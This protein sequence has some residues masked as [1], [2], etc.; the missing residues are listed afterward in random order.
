MARPLLLTNSR[1][2]VCGYCAFAIVRGGMVIQAGE[3]LISTGISGSRMGLSQHIFHGASPAMRVLERTIADIAPTDIPILLVGESGTGKEVI[4]LEIHRLSARWK[5]PF[6]KYSCSG[7][8]ADSIAARLHCGENV[9][10]EG[11]MS[12]GSLFLD[13][14]NQLEPAA[15]ARLLS[16]L[17][18][19]CGMPSSG[20]LSV[21]VISS[22]T[23]NLEDEMRNARFR[24]ELY[25]RIN[26]VHLRLPPL[27]SRKED[28]PALLEFFLEKYASLFGRPTPHLSTPTMDLLLRHAWPG[29]IRELENFARKMV[30]LGNEHLATHDLTC[31]DTQKNPE[32]VLS[33]A[34]LPENENAPG[35][36]LKE[37]AR[38]ASRQAERKMILNQLEH[39]RWNRKRTARELQI[40]YKALL[41]KLKQLGLD[42]SDHT[43]GQ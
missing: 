22:T 14:I 9:S 27:R 32:S 16:L 30:A 20:C 3:N 1:A 28:I 5:E 2:T 18:D 42:G 29:N 39:T 8:T 6:V 11:A 40:S 36:S 15:Q 4:A 26:G 13:E 38:E 33:P 37:A 21:R 43:D 31:R 24:E 41:Y 35:R 25:Y 34:R 12:G 17:P 23:H 19:G 7:L 10:E